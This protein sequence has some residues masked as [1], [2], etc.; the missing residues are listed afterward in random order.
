MPVIRFSIIPK[1]GRQR[2]TDRDKERQIETKRDTE[3]QGQRRDRYKTVHG[4]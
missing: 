4:P 2:E 1:R 3:R